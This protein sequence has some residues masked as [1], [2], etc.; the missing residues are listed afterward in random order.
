MTNDGMFWAAAV[1]VAAGLAVWGRQPKRMIVHWIAKP[2]TM[3]LI[4]GAVFWLAPETTYRDIVLAAL[5]I[6]LVGDVILMIAGLG[7]FVAALGVFLVALFAYAA[8]LGWGM[9][10]VGWQGLALVPVVLI[11]AAA[12]WPLWPHLGSLRP[13]MLVYTFVLCIMVWRAVCRVGVPELGLRG[14]AFGVVGAALLLGGNVFLTYRHFAKQ[15]VPYPL[16][17]GTYVLAQWCLAATTWS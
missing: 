1:M 7:A 4:A 2:L 15:E 17:L 10:V 3:L 11:G 5:G 13:T 9:Q 8:A 6:S 12:V 14:A 16:E